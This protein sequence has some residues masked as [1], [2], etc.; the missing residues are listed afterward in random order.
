[1]E[2]GEYEDYLFDL[3]WLTNTPLPPH[4]RP[5]HAGEEVY[6]EE[7]SKLMQNKPQDGCR[8]P[9]SMLA[10]ILWYLPG[11]INQRHATI[12]AT[13]VCWLGTSCGQ[14]VVLNGK[15]FQESNLFHSDTCYSIA[16]HLENQRQASVNHGFRTLEH[17]LAPEDHYGTDMLG[18]GGRCVVKRPTLSVDDFETVEHLMHWLGRHGAGFILGCEHRVRERTDWERVQRW[19]KLKKPAKE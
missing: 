4:P 6:A 14:A 5:K 8:A 7:W 12:C 3:G 1:M 13:V 18:F 10:E 11:R 15:R 19:E 17:L 2:S 9:N 16:W